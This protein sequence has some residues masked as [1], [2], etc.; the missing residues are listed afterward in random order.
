[1]ASHSVE[2]HRS[3][4]VSRRH[5]VKAAALAGVSFPFAACA[6]QAVGQADLVVEGGTFLPMDPS[7]TQVDAMAIRGDRI[8]AIGRTQDI[9]AL[10]GPNT[11]RIDARNLT[12]T[13]GFIDAHSHPMMANEAISVDV[14]FRTIG[15]VQD[16][17]VRQADK[18]PAGEWVLAH[19]YDDT[20]FDEG[21]P[22]NRDDIDQ[23]VQSHPV[24]V[25]HRGG[26]TAVVNSQAFEI[27]DITNDTPDPEGGRYFRDRG[28]LTGK[29]AEKAM[30]AFNDVGT[31][32]TTDRDIAR[33]SATLMSKRMA[34]AGLT[35]TTDA[36]GQMSSW[37][38]YMD[39][40]ERDELYFRLS[41]MPG[42]PFP[43]YEHMKS[44]GMRS[45]YGSDMLRVG[46]VKYV[47]DGSA[48]ERTMRMSTPYEGTNDY[49]ISTMSQAEIDE[50]VDEAVASG[51]RIGIHA[52]GDVTIDM[53]LKAYERVLANREGPNPRFRIEHCSLTNPD[54]LTRIKETGTIPAPFYTYAHY[55]GN[56]WVDYGEERM[57]NMFAHRS[58]LDYDIPV[59]PASDFTPGPFEPMMALQSMVT[60][61]DTSGRV[62]GEN[63]RISVME[64]LRICTLN[65]AFASFEEETKGS[66]TTG[67][68]ADFVLLA[69][70]PTEVDP[71]ALK[72]IKVVAT[73]LGGRPTY[74]A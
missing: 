8:I 38:A 73:Y 64:A 21:R 14:N 13:P 25:R 55:H 36:Y 56:K 23:V 74:E 22:L 11:H 69:Q 62:W 35:S 37:T 44:Q 50:A 5:F 71:A 15:E 34:T 18:T 53:V 27:A 9:E 40:L 70:N 65:G 49:G 45:G 63:Q 67:K 2:P 20:K 60:R 19:M 33:T 52:N 26:H 6:N 29:V 28:R 12:V 51:F 43:V 1:M 59:A 32:P 68:L 42:G 48:S 58:F 24:M 16:A 66:L 41:F 31:W 10:V 3:R 61:K 54:L 46:A 47:A 72:E 7:L 57:R 30:D 4:A 39:A 17:L